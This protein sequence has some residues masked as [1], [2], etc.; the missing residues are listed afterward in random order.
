MLQSLIDQLCT[1]I[2]CIRPGCLVC[3]RSTWRYL[4][5]V[6]LDNV[7]PLRRY[8]VIC[9]KDRINDETDNL[10]RYIGSISPKCPEL[11]ILVSELFLDR[12]TVKQYE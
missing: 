11:T 8:G 1:N 10:C 5:S 2:F 9:T 6:V 12:A 7:D 4:S 3:N